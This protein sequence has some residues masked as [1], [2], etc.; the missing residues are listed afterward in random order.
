MSNR[1]FG[2]IVG[3]TISDK[4][5]VYGIVSEVR[6]I[7]QNNETFFIAVL[8]TGKAMRMS[9]IAN[10]FYH[11]KLRLRKKGDD[12]IV[13]AWSNDYTVSKQKFGPQSKRIVSPCVTG[14]IN[15]TATIGDEKINITSHISSGNPVYYSKQSMGETK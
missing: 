2:S 5:R 14:N 7:T 10:L 8:D 6:E 1:V 4:N 12:F 3:N 9:T 11:Q 13:Y 15:N